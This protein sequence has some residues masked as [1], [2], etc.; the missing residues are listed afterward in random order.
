[1]TQQMLPR[2]KEY[3]SMRVI[4]GKAR[5]RRLVTREGS[6]TRPTPERVKEA[7]FNIIQF[8]VEGRRVLDAFAGSGQLGIETL[9]RGA[10][11]ADF[12][13][14]SKE[15]VAVIQKNLE[16]TGLAQQASVFQT[17]TLL[18]LQRKSLPYDICFLDPPYRTG[19]LQQALPLCAAIMNPGGMILCEY[20]ADEKLPDTVGLFQRY[21]TYKYGKIMIT[22]FV[23]KDV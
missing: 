9:S 2:E 4:A 19:L 17:D 7:I 3:D 14:R 8:Q 6:E 16:S 18:F 11:H 13:D 20:P 23:H 1:M 12:I 5:G 10:A 22:T 15:S 21:R